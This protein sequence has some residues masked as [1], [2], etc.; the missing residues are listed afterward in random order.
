LKTRVFRNPESQ[1][2]PELLTLFID[3]ETDSH[4]LCDLFTVTWLFYQAK[5]RIPLFH[6]G[7]G[8]GGAGGD[9]DIHIY[10]VIVKG[11]LN[12]IY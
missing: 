3:K 11:L 7:G 6:Y 1:T 8:G 12:F 4:I 5:T 10:N 9:G 2:R